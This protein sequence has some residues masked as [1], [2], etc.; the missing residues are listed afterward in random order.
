MYP[1]NISGAD[2]WVIFHIN[3]NIQRAYTYRELLGSEKDTRLAAIKEQDKQKT[4]IKLIVPYQSAE[5]ASIITKYEQDNPQIKISVSYFRKNVEEFNPTD[6]S[7][8]VSASILSGEQSWDILS[9]QYLPYRTLAERE[10][11]ASLDSISDAL[12][13]SVE[14]QYLPN[15]LEASSIDGNHYILPTKISMNVVIANRKAAES[16][17]PSTYSWN[18]L[19]DASKSFRYA[20]NQKP[21]WFQSSGF[22]FNSV[23]EPVF[24]SLEPSLRTEAAN[25]NKIMYLAKYAEQDNIMFKDTYTKLE[26]QDDMTESKKQVIQSLRSIVEQLNSVYYFGSNIIDAL[27]DTTKQYIEGMTDEQAAVQTILDKLWLYENE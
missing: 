5:F 20:S 6:Y 15:I 8:Y 9:T 11:L 25:K 18:D 2:A 3:R 4:L 23:F 21:W 27:Y 24:S 10:A 7:S 12:W 1:S 17:H 26:Q 14:D 22:N 19:I 16:L 13:H